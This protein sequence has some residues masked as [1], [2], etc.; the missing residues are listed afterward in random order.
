MVNNSTEET[1]ARPATSVNSMTSD[2]RMSTATVIVTDPV[3]DVDRTTLGIPVSLLWVPYII[4]TLV[5][6]SL[7]AASFCKFHR[8][9]GH[10]Y[11]R[12]RMELFQQINMNQILNQL[13][14]G[15][16]TG[17]P[18]NGGTANATRQLPTTS[19][20]SGGKNA[21]SSNTNSNAKKKTK[22]R[23]KQRPLTF[24]RNANGSMVD[25]RCGERASMNIFKTPFS[26]HT[27]SS[28]WT[29]PS[30]G[31]AYRTLSPTSGNYFSDEDDD[32][33]LLIHSTK[34]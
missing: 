15:D 14:A 31:G 2:N 34:L 11:R 27:E 32:E 1:M 24:M 8:K 28:I 23:R 22:T 16:S 33:I 13:Q 25:L 30:R 9:N 17:L 6:I 26:T 7:M 12:R 10:K 4:F 20:N 5:I 21:I 3:D 18:P 19:V 29:L